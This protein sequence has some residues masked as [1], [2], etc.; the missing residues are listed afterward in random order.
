MLAA[1]Q[2]L[3][4]WGLHLGQGDLP[5]GEARR[6]QGLE[7]LHF[8]TSTHGPEEW[9]SPD[10]ACDHAGLGPF[11]ATDTKG[12][13][14]PPMGLAGLQKGCTALRAL[15]LAPVAIGGLTLEDA[16]ACFQAGAESLAM[17]GAVARS[18][19]PGELLWEAQVAR[20][21][22]RPPVDRG[23][24]VVLIGGSGSGKSALAPALAERLGLAALDSDH[25]VEVDAGRTVT[26]LFAQ[27]GEAAFRDLEA[28]AVVACLGAPAVVAL[29]AGAWEFEATRE[30]VRASGFDV[31][32][33]AEVPARAWARVAGDAARPLALDRAT[34]MG[35]WA[36]RRERWWEAP[37]VLPLGRSPQGLAEALA[38]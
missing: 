3:K 22:L 30:Q 8:G 2:G 18:E 21:R 24:G 19:A 12:D 11:R 28:K 13:H 31:L 29:G 33:L 38:R 9:A 36:R 23:R 15:G 37:M 6:L 20:W 25:V 7:D 4:P 34:F 1:A 27:R 32:W 17:V 35:R 26:E 16:P 5:P 14:A 10:P